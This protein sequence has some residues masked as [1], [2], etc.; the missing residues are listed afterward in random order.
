MTKVEESS[1]S[2]NKFSSENEFPGS[3][4]WDSRNAVFFTKMAIEEAAKLYGPIFK[5]MAS[6]YALKFE[7]EKLKEN[8]PE[9]IQGLDEVMNYIMANLDRYPNGHCALVYSIFKTEYTL[10]GFSASGGK[11]AVYGAQKSIMENSGL[12]NGV[13]GTI[14]DVFEACKKVHETAT[15][16]KVAVPAHFIRVENNQVNIVFHPDC[17]HKDACM[18]FVDEGISRMVGGLECVILGLINAGVEIITKK[19]FDYVLEEFNTPVCRG[20]IWEP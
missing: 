4:E 19:H 8:P 13:V 12:L 11:R 1:K 3:F 10:Q 9:N 20:R 6:K 7:A 16:T 18:A 2:Q 14:E 15:L 5:Q 17:T